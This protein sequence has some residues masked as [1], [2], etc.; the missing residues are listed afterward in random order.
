VYRKSIPGGR[1][2]GKVWQG[3]VAVNLRGK[4]ADSCSWPVQRKKMSLSLMQNILC[5]CGNCLKEVGVKN[6]VH[7]VVEQD[8]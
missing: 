7:V 2:A 8:T 1:G 6:T 4:Q 5:H 3:L